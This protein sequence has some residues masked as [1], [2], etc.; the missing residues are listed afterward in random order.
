MYVLTNLDNV[1]F[2]N[3]LGVLA[4]GLTHDVFKLETLVYDFASHTHDQVFRFFVYC[5]RSSEVLLVLI[6]EGSVGLGL[7]LGHALDKHDL[8]D[9]GHSLDFEVTDHFLLVVLTQHQVLL[10]QESFEVAH[11]C[12][13]L[14]WEE[15]FEVSA[16]VAI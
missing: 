16:I 12:L 2:S 7:E 6:A 15:A 8:A 4:A 9:E 11:S 1:I 10:A 13:E 5:H 14:S 3:D